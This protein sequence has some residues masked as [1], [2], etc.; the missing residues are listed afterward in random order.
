MLKDLPT[1][2]DAVQSPGVVALRM[3]G[4]RGLLAAAVEDDHSPQYDPADQ[5]REDAYGQGI[6]HPEPSRN[7]RDGAREHRGNGK[8]AIQA[9]KTGIRAPQLS[10]RL[11]AR[12]AGEMDGLARSAPRRRLRARFNPV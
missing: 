5:Y 3:L 1:V 7:V 6:S 4:P 2:P 9:H 8:K 12:L 11:F 10:A